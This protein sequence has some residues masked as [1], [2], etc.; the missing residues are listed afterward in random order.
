MTNLYRIVLVPL[1]AST[2]IVGNRAAAQSTEPMPTA[3]QAQA[4]QTPS[5]DAP[6]DEDLEGEEIIVV[7]RRDPNAVIGDIP[8]ENQLNPADIRAFG[9]TSVAEL[10]D[11]IAPQTASS[12]GRGGGQP[13]V[14]L[15]GRRTS[16][17]REIRDIPP[18]AILR[19]DILPE[20]VAL[21]YGYRADQRVVNI[22]LR[23]R[24]RS[25][26]AQLEGGLP[27]EGGFSENEVDLTRLMIG[28]NGRTTLN[29]HGE[30]RSALLESE[31]E[32][33][34]TAEEP[35]EPDPRGFRSLIGERR[36]VRGT[37]TINRNLFEDVSSTFNAQVEYSDG[38]S[39]LGPSLIA[40][41]DPL[42]RDTDS[43]SGEAGMA[44]NG[45]QGRWRW[46]FTGEYALAR[47]DTDT[48]REDDLLVAFDDR[49]RTV[50]R[51]GELDL[52]ASGPFLT[53]PAG[54]ANVTLRT[55]ADTQQ[56]ESRATRFG[57]RT[58]TDLSRREVDA[59]LNL[60]LP[61]ARRDEF[62]GAIGNLTL[63]ANMEV[64]RLSDFG[65]L[66][67]WGAGAFW[68]P[69]QEV[70]LITSFTQE[71]GAPSL[72]QLGNPIQSTPNARVFDFVSGRDA[73]VELVTGG[74]PDLE[75]DRRRVM[76]IGGTVRPL[77]E[78]DFELRADFTRSRTR[79]PISNF[80][81]ITAAVEAAFPDRFQRD[82]E[83]NLIRVDLR[84]VNSASYSRDEFRW[85][86]NFSKPLQSTPPSP[87]QQAEFRRRAAAAGVPVPD[88]GQGVG[89]GGERRGQGD[90]QGGRGFG[91]RGGGW[92]GFGG[93]GQGGRGGRL[94]LSVFHT[95]LLK[96]KGLL[97]PGLAP[98]DFLGGQAPEGGLGRS[99]HRIEANG[100]YFNN[101]LGARLSV[102]W[103]SGSLVTGGQSGGLR[104]TPLT[105]INANLFA[106]L[107]QRFDLVNKYPWLR[108]AQARLSIDNVL[109]AKQRVRNAAGLVP[110]N[111]QPDL[112]DAQGRTVRLSLRKLFLPPR[113]YFRRDNQQGG[114]GG[115]SE[116]RAP[117][118]VPPARL[119][120][121]ATS[122][123]SP[124]S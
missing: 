119:P 79:N 56:L 3:V 57:E 48:N 16:G 113:S 96:D 101:G 20:E 63:N 124:G 111:Y 73:T 38:Q 45:N 54:P 86:F 66:K 93:G 114:G 98:I 91:G 4:P 30:R 5:P 122:P 62:L 31:R 15:N 21:K 10:L 115:R 87:A 108:G 25:T 52:V 77:E 51:N 76:K 65:T 33:G 92:G 46:S 82:D 75:S 22:V 69:I 105:K 89:A 43:L 34:F 84:P 13:V 109:N 88:A 42:I 120:S 121:P 102:N 27:T 90:R 72:G 26:S 23:P 12:R 97:A 112:L 55:G 29:L 11:A 19:T 61:V 74:N 78:K 53:L 18:E 40:I 32:I 37:G 80:P 117:P 104:F 8:P 99:Q 85:G 41:G 94:Q 58:E 7:G 103:Q 39:L 50:T 14:L 28:E 100:G 107:G 110:I 116:R 9:V 67:T 118:E 17:F 59:S 47:S 6:S 60:D 35:D 24:F 44:F 106:N 36:M 70:N 68:S 1:L 83:G 123:T 64:E 49:A 81:A 95:V 2:S 71:E